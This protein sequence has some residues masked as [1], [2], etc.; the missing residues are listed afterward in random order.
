MKEQRCGHSFGVLSELC[1]LETTTR[2]NGTEC[3]AKKQVII[4]SQ[5]YGR[6]N[7]L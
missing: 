3:S 4:F 7:I 2:E 5:E 6:S 1:S